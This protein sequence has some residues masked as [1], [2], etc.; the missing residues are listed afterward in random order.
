VSAELEV[1]E[2]G[3][4][5]TIQDLGRPGHAHWG[6]GPSGAAD[7]ASLCL[8]NRLVGNAEDEA[9]L[10]VTAGGLVLRPDVAVSVALTGAPCDATIAG[11]QVGHDAVLRVRAGEEL[12]LGTPRWGLRTYVA[13]RGG[14]RV[15]EVL[16]SRATDVLAEL[17]PRPLEAGDRL[18]I[19][20][21]PAELPVVDLAAVAHPPPEVVELHAVLGPRDDWFTDDALHTFVTATWTVDPASNRVAVALE[22]PPLERRSDDELPSEGM[23]RGAVQVPPEG[24][25]RLFLAD[26]PVTGG[27]PVV[28]VVVDA[29]VD[30]AAQL[31]PGQQVRFRT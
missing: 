4:F 22:G 7:R 9:G 14:L 26:H 30:R 31:R 23:V 13:V 5:T 24:D 16:G 10:E 15:P 20:P 11:R 18:P 25:P 2:P 8:G 17:G 19:G 29:D 3:P 6:V 21:V 28:A 1:V 27:Y 12:R